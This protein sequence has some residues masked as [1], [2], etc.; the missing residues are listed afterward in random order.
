MS[1]PF[2]DLHIAPLAEAYDRSGFA[3]GVESLDRYLKTQ[4]RQDVS[5]RVD[6]VGWLQRVS[7]HIFAEGD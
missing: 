2:R 6:P 4:A 1:P 5:G 7:F 3:C